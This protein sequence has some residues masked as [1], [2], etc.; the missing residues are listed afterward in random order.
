MFTQLLLSYFAMGMSQKSRK[1]MPIPVRE[2]HHLLLRV[3]VSKR[4]RLDT[5]SG[6]ASVMLRVISLP[7]LAV[8][9]PLAHVTAAVSAA[10]LQH[11]T[12]V[13]N[14]DRT[15]ECRTRDGILVEALVKLRLGCN[16]KRSLHMSLNTECVWAIPLAASQLSQ[17]ATEDVII[18]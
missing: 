2:A 11:T 1:Q 16:Q 15:P 9:A 7:T 17:Q 3:G 4:I 12:T 13:D 5:P 14:F 18:C 8:V 6:F 10:R